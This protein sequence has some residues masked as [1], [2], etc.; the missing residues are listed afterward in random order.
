[1]LHERSTKGREK[2]K[3]LS[4]KYKTEKSDN[5]TEEEINKTNQMGTKLY[6]T[7]INN[8][9]ILIPPQAFM[10]SRRRASIFS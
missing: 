6:K 5:T 8:H 7:K 10:A 1:M 3:Y 4:N 9:K 2:L